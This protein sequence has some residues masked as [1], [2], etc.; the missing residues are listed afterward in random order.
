MKPLALITA[1]SL[2]VASTGAFACSFEPVP[3]LQNKRVVQAS[4]CS[5]E[6]GGSQEWITGD[7]VQ[8]LG[9]GKTVQIVRAFF[10]SGLV[11]ADCST[12]ESIVVLGPIVSETSCGPEH[13]ADGLLSPEGNLQIDA[14]K[15][16]S[17]AVVAARQLDLDVWL[18]AERWNM[19]EKRKDRFD[20]MCG[21][22]NFYPELNSEVAR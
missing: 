3:S 8:D 7:A 22:K 12:S 10:T 15:P 20:V 6:N 11:L 18:S 19:R 17:E 1:G 14:S 21:C 16:L 9:D 13:R 2:A 5:F 4:D